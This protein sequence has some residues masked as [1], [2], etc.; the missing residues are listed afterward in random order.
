[1]LYASKTGEKRNRYQIAIL[2]GLFICILEDGL[3]I[4]FLIG[5][6]AFLIGHLFYYLSVIPFTSSN[7]NDSSCPLLKPLYKLEE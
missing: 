1:M 7:F 5:L 6:S 4:W 2:L 3:L